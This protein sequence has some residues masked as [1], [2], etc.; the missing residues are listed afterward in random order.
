MADAILERVVAAVGD[1]PWMTPDQGARV[2]RHLRD[3]GAR[4][5]L[6]IGTCYGV[7]AAYLAAAVHAN[8]GGR[9]V[10]VDSGRFDDESPARE[11]ADQIL[12]RAGLTDL[13]EFVRIDHSS[14]AWWLKEE[15]ERRSD[16]HGNCE[17]AY[18]FVLLDG[19]KSLT[20]DGVSVVLIER[21]LR[22]GG[23]LL[24]DD[25]NWTFDSN[26]RVQQTEGVHYPLSAAELATPHIRDVFDLIVKPSPSFTELRI[27]DEQWGWARKAPGAARRLEVEFT[28]TA[29]DRA[30]ARVRRLGSVARSAA[31][32]SLR[33]GHG[34]PPDPP[35]QAAAHAAAARP[36]P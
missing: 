20:I 33:L 34:V 30:R 28:R 13:V 36:R 15:V 3:A 4:D 11:M 26:P 29:R 24:L 9:V 19:A 32:R 14:Y 21:L 17:P 5:A 10:T 35:A 25:L 16:E 2:Y 7:S 23:W 27:Q 1:T 6:D 22:P 18:D 31:R 8:G 12:Q